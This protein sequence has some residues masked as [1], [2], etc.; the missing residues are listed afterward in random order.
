VVGIIKPRLEETFEI[1]KDKLDQ[2]GLGKEGGARV[3]LTG[4]AFR[5]LI[6]WLK[7]RV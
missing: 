6:H 3:V 4:G 2:S 1:L 7:D 5:R